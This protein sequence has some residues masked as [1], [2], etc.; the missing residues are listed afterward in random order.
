MA[1]TIQLPD[2][3]YERIKRF[4][5]DLSFSE[6]INILLDDYRRKKR[7]SKVEF[8]NFLENLENLYRNRKKE[9]VSERIDE[10]L[11]R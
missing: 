7:M 11:W 4:K 9:R 8:L 5:K 1:K 10:I 3:V 6:M 2:D